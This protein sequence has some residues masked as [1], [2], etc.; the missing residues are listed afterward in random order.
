MTQYRIVK[1]YSD[2]YKIECRYTLWNDTFSEWE[3]ISYK[4][5]TF[6]WHAKWILEGYV[7]RDIDRK[8]E[9]EFIEPVVYGP[10]PP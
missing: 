6:L 1:T 5:Y 9:R 7:A 8:K 2:G 4:R 10:Y 3:G